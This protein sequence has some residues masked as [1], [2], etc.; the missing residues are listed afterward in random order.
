[1]IFEP[2]DNG[3]KKLNDTPESP[4]VARI[5]RRK[6]TFM[7]M[8]RRPADAVTEPPERQR[9]KF[10]PFVPYRRTRPERPPMKLFFRDG[11]RNLEDNGNDASLADREEHSGQAEMTVASGLLKTQITYSFDLDFSSASSPETTGSAIAAN[12]AVFDMFNEQ[13]AVDVAL[14]CLQIETD[15]GMVCS[16]ELPASLMNNGSVLAVSGVVSTPTPSFGESMGEGQ[17]GRSA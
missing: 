10:I 4:D 7:E 13:T 14:A 17:F 2:L 3:L 9:F 16:T 5:N 12:P 1:M 8:I 15:S 6:L 11:I